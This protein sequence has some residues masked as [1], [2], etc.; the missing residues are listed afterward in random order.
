M[1]CNNFLKMLN[2]PQASVAR[3]VVILNFSRT[4]SQIISLLIIAII[5][6]LIQRFIGQ[7]NFPFYLL[8][9]G[10]Y[11]VFVYNIPSQPIIF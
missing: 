3:Q 4:V 2:P 1:F 10:R 9:L 11:Y 8:P 6:K 7:K 5:F